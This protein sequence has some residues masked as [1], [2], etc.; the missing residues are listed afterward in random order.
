[1]KSTVFIHTYKTQLLGAKVAEY[2]LRRNS[3]NADKFDVQIIE[4][5]TFPQLTKH[6][7]DTFTRNGE[8]V[9]WHYSEMQS[10]TTLRFLP[11]QLMDF[12]GRSMVIDPDIF[13]VGDVWELLS[14]DM[15]DKAIMCRESKTGR[16]YET[17]SMLMDNAKLSH[18]KW[19]TQIEEMFAGKRDYQ[20]WVLLELEDPNSLG[21][22]ENK[23]NDFDHLDAN[24]KLLHNTRRITQPWRTGLIFEDKHK[25]GKKPKSG[26]KKIMHGILGR[27]HDYH[28]PHPDVNQQN[29]FF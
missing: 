13:A 16:S 22:F 17:S 12:Q 28:R 8:D 1:M 25:A 4:V 26:L 10:F 3:Q 2:S 15:G 9:V 7:G 20:K 27:K 29:F 11:P 6:D 23:W 21:F 18:W 5:D 19:D 14:C 24:T